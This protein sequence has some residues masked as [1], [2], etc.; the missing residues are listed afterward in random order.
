MKTKFNI[1]ILLRSSSYKE[2]KETNPILERGEIIMITEL[3]WYKSCFG[4]KPI[5]IKIGD[6]KKSFN[7]LRFI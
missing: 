6:G 5:R 7:K 1:K 3:P 2:W 4:L